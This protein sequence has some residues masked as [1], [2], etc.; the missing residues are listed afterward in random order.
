MRLRLVCFLLSF[1]VQLHSHCTY[2]KFYGQRL[3]TFY[4]FWVSTQLLSFSLAYLYPF[5]LL[6]VYI[7]GG[8]VWVR[9]AI[10]LICD[11]YGLH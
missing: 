10:S 11:C 1:S 9:E 2:L 7:V 6:R 5:G 3:L 8:T 4:F